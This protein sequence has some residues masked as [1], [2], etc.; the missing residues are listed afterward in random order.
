MRSLVNSVVI[1][2][3]S[4]CSESELHMSNMLLR[5]RNISCFRS[6]SVTPI[7]PAP[8]GSSKLFEKALDKVISVMVINPLKRKMK[9]SPTF[10][11]K[12]RAASHLHI[13]LTHR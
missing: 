1:F 5:C 2:K 3:S 8:V 11:E 12:I 10:K 7:R 13:K 4:L 9:T 6:L